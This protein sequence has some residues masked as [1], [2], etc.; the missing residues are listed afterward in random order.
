MESKRCVIGFANCCGGNK[1]CLIER[2]GA[3]DTNHDGA[4]VVVE[5]NRCQAACGNSRQICSCV[6]CR[7]ADPNS[8]GLV[9]IIEIANMELLLPVV[10]ELPAS[11]RMAILLSRWNY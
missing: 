10:I 7:V 1:G 4:I 5:Q 8:V 9:I 2:H 3:A 11:Q 6:N